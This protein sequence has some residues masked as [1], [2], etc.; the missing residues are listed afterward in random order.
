MRKRRSAGARRRRRT[1]RRT[2][3]RGPRRTRPCGPPWRGSLGRRCLPPPGGGCSRR[4]RREPRLRRA[5]GRREARG[6]GGGRRGAVLG[7]VAGDVERDLRVRRLDEVDHR[8]HLGVRV[9]APRVQERGELDVRP[10]RSRPD[11][12]E[13]GRE[14]PA[15]DLAVEGR[16]HRFQVDVHRVHEGE[17]LLQRSGV[18]EPVRHQHVLHPR[19]SERLRA[20]QHELELDERLV[21]GVGDADRPLPPRGPDQLVDRHVLDGR[22][23]LDQ[24]PVLAELA[25]DVQP[26]DPT[27]RM[28]A[29]GWKWN[30]GFFSIGS[31]ATGAALPY[32][33][34][35][36]VPPRFSRTPQI[37]DFPRG[38]GIGGGTARTAARPLRAP[39]ARRLSRQYRTSNPR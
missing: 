21:V 38:C 13:D 30:S 35:I 12:V 4:R 39:S 26:T 28:E 2:A 20:V 32:V 34:A 11:R 19:R 29:P 27:E 3:P 37:P 6:R 10:L 23:P 31:I 33:A 24:V 14:L 16:V 17:K 36:S 18:D 8:A 25:A 9:V 1:G 22:L 15:A 5:P 7:E